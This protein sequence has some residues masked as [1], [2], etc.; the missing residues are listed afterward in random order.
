MYLG[1]K[2]NHCLRSRQ[3]TQIIIGSEHWLTGIY[4]RRTEIVG[5]FLFKSLC[6]CAVNSP[7]ARNGWLHAQ[8]DVTDDTNEGPI[9]TCTRNNVTRFTTDK[10]LLACGLFTHEHTN[11]LSMHNSLL[12]NCYSVIAYLIQFNSI[13]K[14]NAWTRAKSFDSF[15][16]QEN[17]KWINRNN[18]GKLVLSH[19]RFK[20]MP[21]DFDVSF[22]YERIWCAYFWRRRRLE[23]EWLNEWRKSNESDNEVWNDVIA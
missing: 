23:N 10:N 3:Y 18:F 7:S 13:N 11:R 16:S 20:T 12:S 1:E 2:D 15:C 21:I 9:V 19:A 5:S 14:C 22:G 6:E 4:L 17:W 8:V